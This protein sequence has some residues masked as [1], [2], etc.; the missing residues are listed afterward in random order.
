MKKSYLTEIINKL[1]S[2]IDIGKTIYVYA[3]N[4]SSFDGVFL[5]KHLFQFGKVEPIISRDGKIIS[6]S[7]KVKDENNNIKTIIFK[8]SY[9]M[10][11]SSLR[12]LCYSFN[13]ETH[14]GHFPFKLDNINYNGEN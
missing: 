13:V 8:D 6:I 2:S 9:L 5:L 11:T 14:K 4:L 10:L 7:L 12:K 1:I 3:H